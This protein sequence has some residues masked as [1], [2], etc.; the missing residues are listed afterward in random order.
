MNQEQQPENV[1][2]T[3]VIETVSR[4]QQLRDAREATG[5]G[6]EEVAMRLRLSEA[7]VLALEEDELAK[8][9][10]RTFVNGY[11]RSYARLLGLDPQ[12]LLDE[13]SAEVDELVSSIREPDKHGASK[14]PY[15][16]VFGLV[17]VALVVL[18]GMW[19]VSREE[20]PAPVAATFEPQQPSAEST[21]VTVES[22]AVTGEAAVEEP[23]G[24]DAVQESTGGETPPSE[25]PII[26]EPEPTPE[27]V[28]ET[29]AVQDAAPAFGRPVYEA[30]LAGT[31]DA[32]R[33]AQRPQARLRLSF[34]ENCWVEISDAANTQLL[35]RLIEGGQTLELSGQA[36]FR[37][38]LGYAPAVSIQ[39]NDT[40][41]DFSPYQ[42]GDIARFRL[43]SASDN[44][45][46]SE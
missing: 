2:E 18:M 30:P 19:W 33:A 27:I 44:K 46:P 34:T 38:F 21:T 6:I 4:G 45:P 23:V 42:R 8:L 26:T 16:L 12:P 35:Y 32:V 5:W 10:P 39:L 15:T 22:D 14:I 43:G 11:V 25:A 9:P 31:E 28:P 36:P 7:I 20:A 40:A 1:E 37:I 17:L 24:E 29:P 3:P 13:G 41:F